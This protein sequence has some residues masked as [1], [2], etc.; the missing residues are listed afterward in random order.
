MSEIVLK[1]R[2]IAQQILYF[3]G[4]YL[5]GDISAEHLVHH[6]S[7]AIMQ[8]DGGFSYTRHVA[9]LQKQLTYER[10]CRAALE[11][12]HEPVHEEVRRALTALAL[13]TDASMPAW[14]ID[15]PAVVA[16]VPGEK[17]AKDAHDA[18]VVRVQR[19]RLGTEEVKYTV[20]IEPH[21][22]RPKRKA[23]G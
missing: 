12:K 11:R 13:L 3:V 1:E 6:V 8:S 7:S 19:E 17:V 20:Q 5:T 18:V 15:S 16:Y 21:P 14:V 22:H 10:S 9:A 4:R 2:P 23:G